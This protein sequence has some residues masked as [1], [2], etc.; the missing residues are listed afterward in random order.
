MTDG[1]GG[2]ATAGE[3]NKTVTHTFVI[4]IATSPLTLAGGL[5]D[6][7]PDENQTRPHPPLLPTAF[8][9]F[10]S[11]A[12]SR[13]HVSSQSADWDQPMAVGNKSFIPSHMNKGLSS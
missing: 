11:S 13:T 1:H 9:L 6:H 4:A 7:V 3:R 5:H 12:P 10:P 2:A 8:S